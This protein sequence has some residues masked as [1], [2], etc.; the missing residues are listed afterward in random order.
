MSF[1]AASVG[2]AVAG[3]GASLYASNQQAESA[4]QALAFQKQQYA[5]SQK[6]I[7]PYL[8][9]GQSAL[10]YL[11]RLNN[12]DMSKFY[13]SPDYNFRLN[14][15][16]N[17]LQNSAAARGGLLSGNAMR[18][19]SDYGQNTAASE[20][21]NYWNRMFQQSQMGQNAAVGQGSLGANYAGMVGNTMMGQGQANASG[22]VGAANSLNGGFQNA[23]YLNYLNNKNPSAYAPAP[24]QY[25]WNGSYGGGG[26]GDVGPT[27]AMT[28]GG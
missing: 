8:Q 17:T 5:D 27:L 26:A 12:G 9:Q 10:G 20:F 23:A 25:Q 2:G 21:G 6:K 16:L 4:A 14:Q 15:G 18:A 7:A 1:L 3:A 22:V 13:T 28:T 24:A 11:N 19:I